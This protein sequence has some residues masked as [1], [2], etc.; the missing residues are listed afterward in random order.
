LGPLQDKILAELK[1]KASAA[2]GLE[3]KFVREIYSHYTLQQLANHRAIVLF[4]YAV[5]T[6]SII[7]FYVSAIPMFIPSVE[8]LVKIKENMNERTTG[9]KGFCNDIQV[10]IEPADNSSMH[11]YSPNDDSDEAFK[12]WMP[13]ADYFQWPYV[14]VFDSYDD[15]FFKLKTLDLKEIS[16]K[17]KSYNKVKEADLLDNW[18]RVL[19]HETRGA[20][21]PGS[22]EEALAYFNMKY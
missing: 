6:Y 18:C 14:T 8:F 10:E 19:K 17:M 21:M 15:L 7:D 12:H 13:Y 22:F 3:F 20:T 1:K 16:N 2:H 9:F 4:P 11:M 5:M